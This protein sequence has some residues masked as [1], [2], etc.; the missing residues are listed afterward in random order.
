MSK[1]IV[2]LLVFSFIIGCSTLPEPEI[3]TL[4]DIETEEIAD[5]LI[6]HLPIGSNVLVFDMTD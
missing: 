2:L 4:F 1:C 6:T 5:S 3:E